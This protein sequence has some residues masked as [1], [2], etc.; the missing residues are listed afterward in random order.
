[1]TEIHS[2]SAPTITATKRPRG[3]PS[4]LKCPRPRAEIQRAYRTRLAAAA[5]AFREAEA[6]SG[7]TA[8]TSALATTHS[9][10][11]ETH[12]ICDRAVFER[13]RYD[14]NIALLNIDTKTPIGRTMMKQMAGAFIEFERATFGG[15]TPPGLTPSRAKGRT[16][17]RCKKLNANERR[18]IAESV[19]SGR[20]SCADMARLYNVSP[21]TVSRIVARHRIGSD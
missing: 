21:P 2:A 6:K 19:L 4:G 3:R 1:M 15:A 8:L 16:Y 5:E 9:Y 14:L 11:P 7:T 10:D 12:F 20:T 17:G 18:N 13:L